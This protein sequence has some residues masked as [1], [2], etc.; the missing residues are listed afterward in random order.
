MSITAVALVARSERGTTQARLL[1]CREGQSERLYW[2]KFHNNPQGPHT[3]IHEWIC[4]R[5]ARHLGLP[6][7][8]PAIIEL[9]QAFIDAHPDLWMHD[10]HY[11]V[12]PPCAGLHLGSRAVEALGPEAAAR[13]THRSAFAGIFAFDLWTDQV[14]QRQVVYIEHQG[15]VRAVFID[16]GQAFCGNVTGGYPL[17]FTD[18]RASPFS[19]GFDYSCFQCWRDFEPW[20]TRIEAITREQL[21]A[22]VQGFPP[23]W[24][25][26]LGPWITNESGESRRQDTIS[27]LNH[28]LKTRAEVR[29]TVAHSIRYSGQFPHWSDPLPIGDSYQAAPAAA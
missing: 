25:E 16:F 23:Q 20:L 10:K 22:C 4:T 9:S 29:D 12:I 15:Q 8:A 2:V 7:P 17:E 11:G 6:V 3:L 13:C 28:L 21:L 19:P 18:G 1:R 27:S 26:P 24:F 14:D 5:L